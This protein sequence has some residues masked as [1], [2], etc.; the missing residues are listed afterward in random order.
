MSLLTFRR[1]S[2]IL[3]RENQLLREQ[4]N[5]V[6]SHSDRRPSTSPSDAIASRSPLS[7][8]SGLENH[9]PR[10]QLPYPE[11]NRDPVPP[12]AAPLDIGTTLPRSLDDVMLAHTEIDEIF[13]L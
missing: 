10:V 1:K 4:L 11:I 6:Y 7:A 12:A 2:A 8:F 3:A 13:A 9:E 5:S